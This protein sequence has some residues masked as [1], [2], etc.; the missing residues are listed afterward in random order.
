MTTPDLHNEYAVVDDLGQLMGVPARYWDIEKAA[1]AI[2]RLLDDRIEAM[3]VSAERGQAL[4][5]GSADPVFGSKK[6]NAAEKDMCREWIDAYEVNAHRRYTVMVRQ[7][8]PWKAVT[9]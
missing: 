5:D 7:V 3:R 1:Q 6:L 9:P 4:L 2:K 8:G